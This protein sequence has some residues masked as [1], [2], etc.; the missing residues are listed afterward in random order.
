MVFQ[1]ATHRHT[2]ILRTFAA[3]RQIFTR[4]LEPSLGQLPDA[5]VD[6][7]APPAGPQHSVHLSWKAS[8][9][10]VVG[11]NVYRRDTTGPPI[12]LNTRPIN[13]TSYVDTSVQPG[14]TYFYFAKGVNSSGRESVPSNE[15]QAVIPP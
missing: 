11:Y 1:H 15:V 14:K 5:K 2:G 3:A 13:D 10:T 4:T 9:S 6:P 7:T 8:T 12:R